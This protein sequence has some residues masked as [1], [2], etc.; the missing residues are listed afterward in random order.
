MSDNAW[1]QE[2]K[3][4]DEVIVMFD[5]EGYTWAVLPV[6]RTTKTQVIVEVGASDRRFKRNDGLIMGGYTRS[7]LRQWTEA[8]E[9]ELVAKREERETRANA[10]KEINQINWRWLTVDQ[11]SRILVIAGEKG[12]E[13]A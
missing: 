7:Y 2:L 8:N 12:D 10:M 3:A 13:N 5:R 6:T 4:G 1:L 11:L 9:A